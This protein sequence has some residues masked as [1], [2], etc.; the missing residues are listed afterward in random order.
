MPKDKKV[1]ETEAE[2][3]AFVVCHGVSLD[4]NTAS[5]DYIQF[6]KG[7]TALKKSEKKWL[8]DICARLRQIFHEKIP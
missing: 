6:Y 8:F 5:S 3:I 7:R 2:A 4:V 1:R